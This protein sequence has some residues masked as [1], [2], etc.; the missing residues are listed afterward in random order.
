MK[1]MKQRVLPVCGFDD[2]DDSDLGYLDRRELCRET[3]DRNREIIQNNLEQ[4]KEQGLPPEEFVVMV[5][6]AHNLEEARLMSNGLGVDLG[7]LAPEDDEDS[8]PIQF[9]YPEDRA[10]LQNGLDETDPESAE[11]L[12]NAEGYVAVVIDHEIA[13]VFS[14]N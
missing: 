5:S 14:L 3:F 13:A 11:S 6:V 12:R 1:E 2:D 4:V 7:E 10:E 9:I 8:W